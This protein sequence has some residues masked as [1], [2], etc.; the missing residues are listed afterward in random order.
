MSSFRFYKSLLINKQ[1]NN[2]WCVQVCALNYDATG[3]TCSI[4]RCA[5]DSRDRDARLQ[6][7]VPCASKSYP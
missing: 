4:L 3:T 2:Q 5:D 1:R 6:R 7:V